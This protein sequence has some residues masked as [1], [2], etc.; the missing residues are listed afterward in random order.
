MSIAVLHTVAALLDVGSM[1]QVR[2][3]CKAW[4]Q[5]ASAAV[6]S[7]RPRITGSLG[8]QWCNL[9]LLS[10]AFP[11]CEVLDLRSYKVPPDSGQYF[12]ATAFTKILLSNLEA[13]PD[14]ERAFQELR[15]YVICASRHQDSLSFEIDIHMIH[16]FGLLGSADEPFTD[17]LC[18][19]LVHFPSSASI[20]KLNVGSMP[21]P[22]TGIGLSYIGLLTSL[23]ELALISCTDIDEV[24]LQRLSALTCLTELKIGPLKQC[25]SHGL[26]LMLSHLCHL[27]KLSLTDA[28]WISDECLI[29]FLTSLS[30]SLQALSL[31]NC[32]QI[33]DESMPYFGRL[34]LSTLFFSNAPHVTLQAVEDLVAQSPALTDL[35]FRGCACLTVRDRMKLQQRLLAQQTRHIRLD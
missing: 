34:H 15:D 30:T 16:Q 25:S 1:Q 7:L 17:E 29:Q 31:G 3:V 20:T 8:V 24:H 9:P 13:G 5:P 23:T 35:D 18:W 26:E 32:P 21:V 11:A 6:S 19:M 28:I 10:K 4:Q 14:H 2:L 12:Q 27:Q 22:V 33:T